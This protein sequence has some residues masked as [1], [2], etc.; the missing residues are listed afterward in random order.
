[1]L[2]TLQQFLGCLIRLTSDYGFI[3]IIDN[4]IIQ[5]RYTQFVDEFLKKLGYQVT[6][7]KSDIKKFILFFYYTCD[8]LKSIL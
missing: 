5:D 1:M 3:T 8:T 2:T 4:K 7:N 6:S